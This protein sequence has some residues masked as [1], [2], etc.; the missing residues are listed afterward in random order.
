MFCATWQFTDRHLA[1]PWASWRETPLSHSF[2][3]HVV[4]SSQPLIIA[5]AR[6]HPLVSDNLAIPDLGVIAYAGIPLTT[7][8]GFTI[9]S[10]C[11]I[12]HIPRDWSQD[13][14]DLLG[15]FAATVLTAIELRAELSEH[16]RTEE[17]LRVSEARY[18]VILEQAP[19]CISM[20]DS[21]GTI[22]FANQALLSVYGISNPRQ[23]VGHY[24]ISDILTSAQPALAD[25]FKRAWA[26][27]TVRYHQ[28][29]DLPTGPYRTERSD[30]LYLDTTL[31]P[32]PGG[33]GQRPHIVIIQEDMTGRMQAEQARLASE[34][35]LRIALAAARMGVWDWDLHSSVVTWAGNQEE[36]FGLA[37]GSFRGTYQAF[38]DC[39][40]PED[41]ALVTRALDR[42]LQESI[43]YDCV[44]RVVWPNNSLHWMAG[45]GEVIWDSDNN[46]VRLIGV[47]MDITEHKQAETA[48]VEREEL[49]RLI[50]E[51]SNDLILL[52]DQNG[53]FIYASPSFNLI[54]GYQPSTL[55]GRSVFEFIHPDDQAAAQAQW[56]STFATASGQITM[57]YRHASGDW[58]WIE[59]SSTV[60]VRQKLPCLVGVARDIT[61]RRRLE[62]QIIQAQKVESIGRLA[63]GIAHDFNNILTAI[64]GYVGLA[65]DTLPQDN[66][67][68]SDLAEV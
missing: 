42:A 27:E 9:G 51:N 52:V 35:R 47:N 4:D 38:I 45:V 57:R 18:R 39:V 67:A 10:L 23:F 65:Q 41:H 14:L 1:E 21:E 46:P 50:T 2:C 33:E 66:P 31:F 34:E 32:V 68:R 8:D 40:H 37:A 29:L 49:Y 36:L 25:H 22:I 28:T 62:A 19:F 15:D 59:A 13:E 61:E 55:I 58:C 56:A 3:Q 43:P 12:D 48:L 6:E 63:G 53:Q 24:T 64:T 26:G 16:Q 44:F 7:A 5:D 17:A 60:I 30:T 54:L 20:C 11:A